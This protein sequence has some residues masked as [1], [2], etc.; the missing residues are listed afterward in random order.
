MSI[1]LFMPAE[2]QEPGADGEAIHKVAETLIVTNYLPPSR[3]VTVDKY[4]HKVL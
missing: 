1:N 3:I 2:R 4:T